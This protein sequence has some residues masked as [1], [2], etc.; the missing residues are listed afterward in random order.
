[1]NNL[2]LGTRLRALRKASGLTQKQLG[3]KIGYDHSRV[4]RMERGDELPGRDYLKQ[5][6]H[7]L[8]LPPSEAAEL[9]ALY[10]QAK[11]LSLSS[12]LPSII[13]QHASAPV[14]SRNLP[15]HSYYPLQK[16]EQLLRQVQSRL[17]QPH[18]KYAI[19][20]CGSG[21]VGKTTLALEAATRLL[22]ERKFADA[23]WVSF[24]RSSL[25]PD[26]S[27][28]NDQMAEFDQLLETFVTQL[29]LEQ[30][31]KQSAVEKRRT[32]A[33][34]FWEKPYLVLLD[35]LE[36]CQN[37]LQLTQQVQS[38]L[39]QSRLL[40]TMRDKRLYEI[41][42]VWLIPVQGLGKRDSSAYMQ[43]EARRLAYQ[44]TKATL[45]QLQNAYTRIGGVPF[46]LKRVLSQT[47]QWGAETALATLKDLSQLE[48][49][50]MYSYL[51]AREW[52]SLDDAARR[53]WIYLG[54]MIP[55]SIAVEHLAKHQLNPADLAPALTQ[56][57]NRS[58]VETNVDADGKA[59][60]VS[61]HP[62]SLQFIQRL[63]GLVPLTT[64]LAEF[65]ES[66][67]VA[68]AA[69]A[70]DRLI[71]A[72]PVLLTETAVRTNIMFCIREC[73]RFG[74]SDHLVM[75][76][77]AVSTPLYEFGYWKDYEQLEKL[78]LDAVRSLDNR[79]LEAE[80][81]GELG[82][83]ALERGEYSQA[84]KFTRIALEVFTALDDKRGIVVA[85]RYLATIQMERKDFRS[86]QIAF[87]E[88]LD[89]I[90]N[91]IES[92]N[93]DLTARLFRQEI[94]A[95][96]SL[97]SVL[98]ELGLYDEAEKELQFG[99]KY[100]LVRGPSSKASSLYN[101]G[102]LRLKQR[103][104]E[105]A[106]SY[107]QECLKFSRANNFQQIAAAALLELANISYLQ[108]NLMRAREFA[109]QAR[110]IFHRIGATPNE[111][112]ASEFL[113]TLS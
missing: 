106:Q 11:L 15:T 49:G 43:T 105:Q 71:R 37:P 60:R 1:M 91:F 93:P 61:L 9:L 56:L 3:K 36:D 94:T 59:K 82:W 67:C 70:W 42:T 16:H 22:E 76:W 33:N 53:L 81:N 111:Q 64:E 17:T 73:A 65:H 92:A 83:L 34:H 13:A 14:H 24:R 89:L 45:R 7:A 74:W 57:L 86:A 5:A 31:V 62:L 58:L 104:M 98:M 48:V 35:N 6:I 20:L 41:D 2:E 18:E 50:A 99:Y 40:V 27:L 87:T 102:L 78:A 75:F 77:D 88:L 112:R 101:L 52:S 10:E 113:V 54:R 85:L 90:A 46:I 96:D 32:I 29:D 68:Q 97:G 38:I 39:G 55:S 28:A 66:K 108:E 109:E 72:Q 4:S 26:F 30:A 80:I 25:A 103:K 8:N 110:R 23:L 63:P 47:E 19:C 107:L 69:Q 44:L 51:F 100:A 95:R 21:G 12:A 79:S 84:E